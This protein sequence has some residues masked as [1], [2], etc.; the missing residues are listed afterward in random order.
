MTEELRIG[1]DCRKCGRRNIEHA[2]GQ[3][4]QP[5]AYAYRG[6]EP[7]CRTCQR[8]YDWEDKICTQS[9]KDPC[10]NGD[11]HQALPPVR[12]YGSKA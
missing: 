2:N 11:R 12:L 4:P 9:K 3:C 7:D 10:T 6:P 5:Q 8:F 1:A